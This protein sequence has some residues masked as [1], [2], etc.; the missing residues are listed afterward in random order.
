MAEARKAMF[1][2]AHDLE[3]GTPVLFMRVP[4]G[5]I[6]DIAA[7]APP[8]VP[9]PLAVEPEPEDEPV[10]A[11]AAVL[12]APPIPP[13]APPERSVATAS[14]SR[15]GRSALRY[16]LVFAGSGVGLLA[17]L[18][19]ALKGYPAMATQ[20]GYAAEA[21]GLPLLA[22]VFALLLALGREQPQIGAGVLLALGFLGVAFGIALGA[23]PAEIDAVAGTGP[24]L[25]LV[26]GLLVLS[27]ASVFA[28]RDSG[29]LASPAA[30]RCGTRQ[31]CWQPQARSC[32]PLRSSSRSGGRTA[33]MRRRA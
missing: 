33:T 12:T 8:V 26:S 13:A 9:A 15:R 31:A 22:A 19:P 20:A 6:F 25:V 29:V 30:G 24:L 10:P 7:Q 23:F 17:T 27:G 11:V 5:R 1:A 3:W 21:I 16:G 2:A 18:F 28:F 32:S 4:D 14:S